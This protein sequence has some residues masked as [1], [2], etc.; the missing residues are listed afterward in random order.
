MELNNAVPDEIIYSTVFNG[1]SRDRSLAKQEALDAA[2][3]LL[4]QI[5][6]QGLRATT[7]TSVELICMFSRLGNLKKAREYYKQMKSRGEFLDKFHSERVMHCLVKLKQPPDKEQFMNLFL[8]MVRETE[9]CGL[10]PSDNRYL[11]WIKA[12]CKVRDNARAAALWDSVKRKRERPKQFLYQ[13]MILAHMNA[14][15]L[16]QSLETLE[17]MTTVGILPDQKVLQILLSSCKRN[18]KR[19]EAERLHEKMKTLNIEP[20]KRLRALLDSMKLE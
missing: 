1:L 17:E 16:D 12:C 13:A 4:L 2:D 14:D 8:D 20:D 11:S 10:G 6:K 9:N 19:A 7:W 3:A 18:K 5:K 15:D